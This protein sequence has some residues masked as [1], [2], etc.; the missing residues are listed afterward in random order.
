MFTL[1][2]KKVASFDHNNQGL[3]F[4]MSDIGNPMIGPGGMGPSGDETYQPLDK[5]LAKP[6]KKS[7]FAKAQQLFGKTADA[8]AQAESGLVDQLKWDSSSDTLEDED[9]KRKEAK[10]RRKAY[11]RASLK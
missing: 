6:V 4:K 10:N 8:P 9:T 3:E 1:G 2:F 5:N 11:V 7:L